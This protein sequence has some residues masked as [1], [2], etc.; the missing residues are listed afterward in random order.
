MCAVAQ[1]GSAISYW[2]SVGS[3]GWMHSARGNL[4]VLLLFLLPQSLTGSL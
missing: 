3:P 1:Q 4:T 2:S